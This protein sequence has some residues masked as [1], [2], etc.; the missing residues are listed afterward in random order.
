MNKSTIVIIVSVV[1]TVLMLMLLG[2]IM[3]NKADQA[4]INKVPEIKELEPRSSEWGKYFP[5][6]YDSYMATK[7][8]DEIKD[9][10]KKDPNLVVLWAGYGFSKDYNEPRGHFYMLEDNI[11][12]LRTG[13]PVDKKTGPMP[14]AC[15]TCKSP[16]VPRLM[17]EKGELDFLPCPCPGCG[18]ERAL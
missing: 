2:S 7:E 3:S 5:R 1:A 6:Q 4:M 11:N 13:A 17:E 18:R 15:W 9:I 16:D 10:L 8:S 14:T 12:T